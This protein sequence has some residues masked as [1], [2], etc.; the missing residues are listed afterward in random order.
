[1]RSTRSS[2]R[3]LDFCLRN[4][5]EAMS[6]TNFFAMNPEV[7]KATLDEKGDNLIRGLENM[8]ADLE[9]GK[10]QLLI[11]QTDMTAFKVGENMAV[12]PGQVIYEN[13]VMQLIQYAPATETVHA[14][15][16][17]IVPPWINKFYIL[18]LNERK[19]MIRWL[20]AQGHTVFVISWV[21][22]DG[23]HRLETWESYMRTG[24]LEALGKALEETGQSQ[25]HMVGYCIGG[26]ML[27]TTLATMAQ[28]GD[29]RAASATFF[30]TLTDFTDA[31]ELQVF[32]DDETLK[33]MAE[34]VGKRGYLDAS[35]MATAF[36]MLRASD[37]I[38]GYVIN[39][40]MLGKE[41][42]PFD[43]LYWNSDSTCM[44]GGVHLYYLETFYRQNRLARG[45]MQLGGHRLD[46]GDVRLPLYHVAT[47]EDHI[48]PAA[49]V[50]RGAQNFGSEEAKFVLSGSG[51]IA[52]VVNPPAGGKYQFWTK[53][54]L[55]GRD[56]AEWRQGTAET[57]G[58]WWPD[59]DGWLA[60]K[61]AE[62]VPARAPGA[63]LGTIEPAPG[64]YVKTRF[65]E[66]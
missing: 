64:R 23:S 57:P 17:L 37:L 1:M 30:T 65:D 49:T 56:L 29:D 27:S 3:K 66:R 24:V 28:E 9:R 11:R 43:L 50:F 52:G 48:A 31:G 19:S 63:V 15:P 53:P 39:N 21:N 4:F 60:A 7:L 61:S 42:F 16:I 32:V 44:P 45:E 35:A 58:S 10:G 25:A 55:E 14:L 36:N 51:H 22:P 20:V 26:T 13:K 6:P 12:T 54:G 8:L 41:P 47:V 62:Q 2:E 59:W 18:D 5:I 46:L 38:W 34:E 40:Y 33:N